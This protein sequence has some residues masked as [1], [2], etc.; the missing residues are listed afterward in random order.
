VILE[1]LAP[2]RRRLYLTIISVVLV[3]VTAAVVVT[4]VRSIG[5]AGVTPVAQDRLGPV[6]L[7]PGYGGS[8]GSLSDLESAL[9][10]QGRDVSIVDLG[11]A[12]GD[13][14]AQA[15]RLNV[16]VHQAL[17]RT[18]AGSVDVVG[19]SAGGVVARYWVAKLG[20]GS[21]ARRVVT[22][23]SPHHGTDVA[24]LAGG[25][26]PDACPEACQQ[27]EPDSDLLNAL[28]QGDETPAGPLWVAMWTDDDETVVPPTS[29]SLEGATDFSVQSICP[30]LKLSHGQMPESPVVIKIVAQ[31][32]GRATPDVPGPSVCS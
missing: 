18:G 27:L 15:G 4:V 28:N 13:L 23:S 16:A 5:G 11:D 8:T 29:G 31:E 3:A 12:T 19:Y 32:I 2:A 25:I 14:R 10:G 9:R 30:G 20:G 7:V 26:A 17:D 1:R 21:L 6:L 24:G 22:I